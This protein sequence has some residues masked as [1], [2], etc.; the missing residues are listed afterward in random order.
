MSGG[1][2]D[3]MYCRIEDYYVGHMKDIELND[4]MKDIVKL[5][6]DLEW[7]DS[8]DISD[9]GYFKTVTKFKNK[10]FKQS[11]KE[12]LKTYI[13]E[14]INKTKNELYILIGSEVENEK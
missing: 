7:A 13:D 2:Y 9:E 8:G 10:W 14:K 1:S 5:L 11:R 3:Y 6:H 4:L 12:R